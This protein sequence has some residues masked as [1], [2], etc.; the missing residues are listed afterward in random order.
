MP[1]RKNR[2]RGARIDSTLAYFG[3]VLWPMLR[4]LAWD[5]RASAK[6]WAR[7]TLMMLYTSNTARWA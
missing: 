6:G 1:R 5:F 4:L 3:H 2:L 7:Q